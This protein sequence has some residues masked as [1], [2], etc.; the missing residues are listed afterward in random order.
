MFGTFATEN[1][2]ADPVPCAA[3]PDGFFRLG[4]GCHRTLREAFAAGELLR[5]QGR[6]LKSPAPFSRGLEGSVAALQCHRR[7]CGR[8]SASPRVLPACW[9]LAHVVSVYGRYERTIATHVGSGAGV[10][11][12]PAWRPAPVVA[13]CWRA[14]CGAGPARE[15]TVTHLVVSPCT[16]GVSLLD[17]TRGSRC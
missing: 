13:R 6:H 7:A 16:S 17:M 14:G 3:W 8:R 12:S 9:A 1:R 5:G 15:H 4:R 10:A 2:R 11:V